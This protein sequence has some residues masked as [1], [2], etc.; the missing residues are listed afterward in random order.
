MSIS[1]SGVRTEANPNY[2]T[3]E[4][5]FCDRYG[6]NSLFNQMPLRSSSLVLNEQSVG[7]SYKWLR[8]QDFSFPIAVDLQ[9][10][11]QRD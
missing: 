5:L 4:W 6:A 11:N 10:E 8:W 3:S 1:L 9:T 7:V 2:A